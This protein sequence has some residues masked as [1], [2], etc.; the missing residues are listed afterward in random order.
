MIQN[1]L[2]QVTNILSGK[3][4]DL[5]KT[6]TSG[7]A[8]GEA[9]GSEW[10]GWQKDKMDAG[11]PVYAG[12]N[13]YAG[14]PNQ[15]QQTQANTLGGLQSSY[16]SPT[17]WQ[18]Q[19][20]NIGA[21]SPDQVAM[22]NRR[23]GVGPGYTNPYE[24]QVVDALKRDSQ[25]MRQNMFNQVGDGS[26]RNNAFGGDRQAVAEAVGGAEINKDVMAQLANVRS[27]G[28]SNAM[29]WFGQDQ[30]RTARAIGQNNNANLAFNDQTLKA[31]QYDI[32][33]QMNFANAQGQYGNY[34]DNKNMMR[35]SWLKGNWDN[36]N[37]REDQWSRDYMSGVSGTPWQKQNV[38]TGQGKSDLMNLV[39][40]GIGLGGA[41]LGSGGFAKGGMFMS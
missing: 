35:D 38:Q 33:N 7:S 30:D 6:S 23:G 19:Y 34:Q 8:A 41:A 25:D 24:S 18:A 37:A 11:A 9:A 5:T 10:L 28:Y 32:N 40:M 4:K 26:N 12:P 21:Q 29:N 16:N 3:P 27:G 20:Q 14:G 17:G 22:M 31:G 2:N 13:P 15:W 39:G 36:R 1:A